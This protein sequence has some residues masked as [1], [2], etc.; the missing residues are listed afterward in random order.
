MVRYVTLNYIDNI[1]LNV[2]GWLFMEYIYDHV[3]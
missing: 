3:I 2:I 1:S